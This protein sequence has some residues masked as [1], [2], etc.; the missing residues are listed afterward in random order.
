MAKTES[1]KNYEVVKVPFTVE[2]IE[3]VLFRQAFPYAKRKSGSND[4]PDAWY[5]LYYSLCGYKKVEATQKARNEAYEAFYKKYP[6]TIKTHI[7]DGK[8]KV[9]F[10]NCKPSKKRNR[11]EYKIYEKALKSLP[12]DRT[13]EEWESINNGFG[14]DVIQATWEAL[15]TQLRWH[16][17]G[18]GLTPEEA[19]EALKT[20]KYRGEVFHIN[21]DTL[22]T[23]AYKGLKQWASTYIEK[24]GYKV[25]EKDEEGRTKVSYHYKSGNISIDTSLNN[26]SADEGI[27]FQL[28][29]FNADIEKEINGKKVFKVYHDFI[30]TLTPEQLEVWELYISAKDEERNI[31]HYI[32][33]VLDMPESAVKSRL[34]RIREK[35]KSFYANYE[36]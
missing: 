30:K 3:E 34:H 18:I 9:Y 10:H 22:Y 20:G 14:K 27:T 33:I 19:T 25:V 8:E 2:A 36:E 17:I 13:L 16:L 12:K 1:A 23:I 11:A 28:E 29:D 4:T 24:H 5:N 32:S 7:I 15:L 26:G 35:A 6:R 31:Y 21:S